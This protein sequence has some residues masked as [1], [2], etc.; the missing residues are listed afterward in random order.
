MYKDDGTAVPYNYGQAIKA[1]MYLVGLFA[2][3]MALSLNY[4]CWEWAADQKFVQLNERMV[5]EEPL[6]SSTRLLSVNSLC[7]GINISPMY[8]KNYY[9]NGYHLLYKTRSE[10]ITGTDYE[11]S[12]L[13][14]HSLSLWSRK[15]ASV[16]N[17]D[18]DTKLAADFKLHTATSE[19]VDDDDEDYDPKE[20][21]VPG[22]K[23]AWGKK[24]K[25]NNNHRNSN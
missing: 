25:R 3:L 9:E 12:S 18:T 23:D 4:R 2:L 1:D 15:R 20:V 10:L 19:E 17:E 11:D 22:S 6:I 5:M 13:S 7:R 14:T 16:S 8:G 24:Q 21:F